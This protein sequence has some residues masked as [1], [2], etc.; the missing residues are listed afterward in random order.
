[1]R[2]LANEEISA[3]LKELECRFL[4][5][6]VADRELELLSKLAIIELGGWVEERFDEIVVEYVQ[7]KLT[8]NE[9]MDRIRK[10]VIDKVYGFDYDSDI[11]PMIERVIGSVN[12]CVIKANLIHSGGYFILK[13]VLGEL[14]HE[15]NRVAHTHWMGVTRKLAAPSSVIN[16]LK[17]IYPHINDIEKCI[18]NM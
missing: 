13:S 17:R 14:R 15:R 6:G 8:D 4:A 2:V 1:M 10:E 18:R 11:R 9:E 7:R 12:Y 3:T 5:D 16:W